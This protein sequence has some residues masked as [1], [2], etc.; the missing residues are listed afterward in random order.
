MLVNKELSLRVNVRFKEE[1]RE[2]I[3]CLMCL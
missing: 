2:S 1:E 3:S